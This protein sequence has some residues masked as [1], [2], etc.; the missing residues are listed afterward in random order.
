MQ[1][2]AS[3]LLVF[4]LLVLSERSV[5]ARPA[6]NRNPG[7]N[8]KAP[9]QHDPFTVAKQTASNDPPIWLRDPVTD[10][11]TGKPACS[12]YSGLL[13]PCCCGAMCPVTWEIC[14]WICGGGMVG[15]NY[16]T[17]G[18][19]T[20]PDFVQCNGF[21]NQV[22]KEKERFEVNVT[23]LGTVGFC[24]VK[25]TIWEY[26]ERP[27]THGGYIS[28]DCQMATS[29]D[30]D[31]IARDAERNNYTFTKLDNSSVIISVHER[32]ENPEIFGH[33]STS[34]ICSLVMGCP[35]ASP[36]LLN[37]GSYA[38]GKGKRW[39]CLHF[40]ADKE[41]ADKRNILVKTSEKNETVCLSVDGANC[42]EFGSA[43]CDAWSKSGNSGQFSLS[44]PFLSC[45]DQQ[46][47]WC[48]LAEQL[49]AKELAASSSDGDR[50]Y[51]KF[52]NGADSLV[53]NNCTF[54]ATL[55]KNNSFDAN[56]QGKP[57]PWTLFDNYHNQIV[58]RTTDNRVECLASNRSDGGG[59]QCWRVESSETLCLSNF[60]NS[61]PSDAQ[62]LVLG[63]SDDGGA[64]GPAQAVGASLGPWMC[65]GECR[66]TSSLEINRSWIQIRSYG[67]RDVLV[68]DGR[69]FN[70]S[71]C[72]FHGSSDSEDSAR[73]CSTSDECLKWRDAVDNGVNSLTCNNHFATSCLTG[74]WTCISSPSDANHSVLVRLGCDNKVQCLGPNATRCSWFSPGD[75]LGRADCKYLKDGEP[76]PDPSNELGMVCDQVEHGWCRTAH[77]TLTRNGELPVPKCCPSSASLQTRTRSAILTSPTSSTVAATS[78]AEIALSTKQRP[79][80]AGPLSSRHLTSHSLIILILYLVVV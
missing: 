39:H 66:A 41:P 1:N 49:L 32:L 13:V 42:L 8:N 5:V 30:W 62:G 76:E 15:P 78:S 68:Q 69:V 77:V 24:R 25:T 65:V 2:T 38:D 72:R 43:C 55:S 14:P 61:A 74:P 22:P 9:N 36:W 17:S 60:V 4:L 26:V 51:S 10:P 67:N 80:A 48:M 3:F 45:A 16:T 31:R 21:D 44:T 34:G 56:P 12:I 63:D 19:W 79:S 37:N 7:E 71:T 75:S 29:C 33:S 46:Q 47:H 53:G 11:A 23:V 64:D 35:V 58:R 40:T 27:R 54:N 6:F 70:D 59:L 20:V 57:G 28:S 18:S 73:S 52:G 50:P